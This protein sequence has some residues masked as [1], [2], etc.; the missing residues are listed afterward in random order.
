M[1]HHLG[2]ACS[3]AERQQQE[4]A[5]LHSQIEVQT[6]DKMDTGIQPKPISIRL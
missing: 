3:F 6:R 4:I 2:L 1:R 5:K